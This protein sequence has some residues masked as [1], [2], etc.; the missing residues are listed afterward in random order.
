MKSQNQKQR[1]RGAEIKSQN[2]KPARSRES[3]TMDGEE[4]RNP[5]RRQRHELNS[6]L[7][8]TARRGGTMRRGPSRASPDDEGSH[9]LSPP[10]A[11]PP[12]TGGEEFKG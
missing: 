2:H 1:G 8:A 6:E 5:S 3:E 4:G 10:A 9:G 11:T 12:S 7:R